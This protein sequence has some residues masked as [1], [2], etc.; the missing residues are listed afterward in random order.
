[1][2]S[3]TPARKKA[4]QLIKHIRPERPDYDYLRELFRHIRKEL[5]VKQMPKPKRHPYVPTAAEIKK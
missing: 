1:M 4:K 2:I 3:R 5:G